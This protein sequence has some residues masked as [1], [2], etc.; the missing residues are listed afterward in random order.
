MLSLRAHNILDYIVGAVLIAC[1][2]VFGFS[3]VLA[4]RDV[5]LFLGVALIA[6]SLLTNYRYSIAKW[7]PINIHMALDVI[8][9]VVLMLSPVIFGY[10][11]N[12]T[13]GQVALHIILG[14]GAIGLVALTNKSVENAKTLE[15][16]SDFR[17]AA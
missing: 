3:G 2:F 15:R 17:K 6:Y 13:G 8:L 7:I 9:G 11:M 10:G 16:H 1:P 12:L 5:F 14:F 4:A